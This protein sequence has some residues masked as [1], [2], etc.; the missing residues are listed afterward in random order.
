M[1]PSISYLAAARGDRVA[2]AA[3]NDAAGTEEA[4]A[5]DEADDAPADPPPR[6]VPRHMLFNT[7]CRYY[8]DGKEGCTRPDCRFLHDEEPL[9]CVV[10]DTDSSGSTCVSCDSPSPDSYYWHVYPQQWVWPDW[11]DSGSVQ[12][13]AED[14]GASTLDDASS[15][16]EAPTK[17]IA[18]QRLY[19]GNMPKG[20]NKTYLRDM[21]GAS[22]VEIVN[23]G[24]NPPRLRC[25]HRSCFLQVNADDAERAVELLN[26]H[27]AFGCELYAHIEKDESQED[28]PD[29]VMYAW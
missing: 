5:A 20:C 7:Y 28:S 23:I 26:G 1:P 25:G 14:F 2:T 27:T 12:S 17:P 21:L 19:V 24:V 8:K 15:H 22:D 9:P 4:A 13:L 16:A 18:I 11:Q 29:C 3:P 6:A 10:Y